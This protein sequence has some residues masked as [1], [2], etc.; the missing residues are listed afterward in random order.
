VIQDVNIV[1]QFPCQKEV[2]LSML[3]PDCRCAGYVPTY[4]RKGWLWCAYSNVLINEAIEVSEEQSFELFQ[5]M[6]RLISK[7]YP[8]D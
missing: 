4:T 7:K 2:T 8:C 5:E 1:I 6:W 3:I